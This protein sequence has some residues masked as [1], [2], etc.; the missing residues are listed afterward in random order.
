MKVYFVIISI[1]LVLFGSI[2]LFLNY[3]LSSYNRLT[4]ILISNNKIGCCYDIG[5]ASLSIPVFNNYRNIPK[6]LC[7][8]ENRIGGATRFNDLSCDALKEKQIQIF[9]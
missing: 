8:T 2:Y 6:F 4:N 9:V 3:K 1:F 7:K 5:F